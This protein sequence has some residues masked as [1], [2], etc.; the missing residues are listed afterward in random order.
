MHAPVRELPQFV[1]CAL[2]VEAGQSKR[3]LRGTYLRGDASSEV[4]VDGGG[5]VRAISWI[6][7]VVTSGIRSDP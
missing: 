3:C 6:L 2:D 7:M 4:F 1:R 5:D